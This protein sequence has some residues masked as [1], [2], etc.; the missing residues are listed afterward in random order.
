MRLPRQL[1]HANPIPR[2]LRPDELLRLAS[3]DV[4][5]VLVEAA[6]PAR[7]GRVRAHVHLRGRV[8]LL[9]LAVDF[10]LRR[11][12]AV[13]RGVFDAEGGVCGGDGVE[14][15][16]FLGAEAELRSF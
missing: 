14:G 3:Y 8:V 1:N 9:G 16:L 4:H 7:D 15:V 11:E 6:V 5:D 13:E 10:F 2:L 12:R